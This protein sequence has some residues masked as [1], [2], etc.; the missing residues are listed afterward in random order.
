MR[1]ALTG[2][3]GT[4]KTTVAALL[5]Y[6]VIDL[7]ALVKGGLNFGIDPERGCLEADMDGLD[8]RLDELDDA[9]ADTITIIEGH[10]SHYFANFAIV[11]RLDP[12][13]LKKRLEARG[14][15]DKKV[16]ENLEAEALDVILVE[17]VESCNRV[18]EI[19]TTGRSTAEVA[20]LVVKIIQGKLRLPP[21]Q[22]S[23]LEDFIDSG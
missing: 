12:Q 16:R 21:G 22:V 1:V 14:Y 6:R 3:P 11:L 18:D 7:N 9:N 17:A 15:Y 8:K 20:E 19:D 5:P 13:E 2:T 4:G 10:F 23:W